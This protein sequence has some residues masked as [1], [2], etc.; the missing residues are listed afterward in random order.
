VLQTDSRCKDADSHI[1][2]VWE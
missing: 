2:V 1:H